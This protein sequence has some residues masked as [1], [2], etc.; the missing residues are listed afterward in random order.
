MSAWKGQTASEIL[1]AQLKALFRRSNLTEDMINIQSRLSVRDPESFAYKI[2]LVS[3]QNRQR[4]IQQE[5]ASVLHLRVQETI[6]L[7]LEGERFHHHAA[8]IGDLS[9]ILSTAQKM[10]TSIVQAIT[11][12]PTQRGPIPIAIEQMA[13][14]RLITTYPSSFGMQLE[15]DTSV[16]MFGNSEVLTALDAFFALLSSGSNREQ[17]TERAGNLGPRVL[18]HY[19][20]FVKQLANSG[21]S[22]SLS[23][24]DPLGDTLRWEAREIELVR[25]HENLTSI[26]TELNHVLVVKGWL[27]GASLLRNRFELVPINEELTINGR[28][29]KNAKNDVAMLFGQLC[30][31]H[32]IETLTFDD[33]SETQK[34]VFTLIAIEPADPE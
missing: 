15:A 26:K 19:K 25:L 28:I 7:A 29:S 24:R 4:A 3:L 10:F 12:G 32:I 20:R 13:R 8:Y 31:A 2:A 18:S 17:L 1:E 16:D 22:I 14:L 6:Y 27:L 34:S 33:V 21:T 30:I 11:T 23:W 5:I 9:V